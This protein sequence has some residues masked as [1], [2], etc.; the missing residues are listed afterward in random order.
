MTPRDSGGTGVR[1]GEATHWRRP[2]DEQPSLNRYLQ[3]LRERSRLIAITIA[4]TFAVAVLYLLVAD[5]QYQAE[6]DLLV[7]P[8]A[9]DQA[10]TGLPLLIQ[11]NDPTR[12]VETAARLTTTRDV[13][14]RAAV[15]VPGDQ[16]EDELLGMVE[17]APVAQSN[18]VAITATADSPELA[19]QVANA[20]AVSLVRDRTQ[21]L[22]RALDQVIA[23]LRQ[24]L[25]SQSA[26][27]EEGIQLRTQLSQLETLRAGPDPSIR[28]ETRATPPDGPSA[29][30]P[31]LTLAA[32]LV[33]GLVLGIG[34]A[35]ALHSV[36]PRLRR[37]EQLRELYQL[38][39][40][41]RI[42]KETRARTATLGRRIL[43]IGPRRKRRKALGPGQLSPATLEAYRTLRTMLAATHPTTRGAGR[44]VLITGP[45]PS[46]GKTTTAI[47]LS[48]SLALGGHRV[49]LI[50][51]D[52][53]RPTV[54]EALGV[55]PAIGI[56]KVLLGTE[57]LEDALVPADPFG[58]KLRLLL[59]DH[60]D[61][62][63]PEVLSL[64]TAGALLDEAGA[65]ADYV[66][67]DSPPLTEVIDALPLAREVDDVVVVVR[68]GGSN[69]T[70]LAR[71]GDLLAQNGIEPSGFVVVGVGRSEKETYYLSAQRERMSAYARGFEDVEEEP[72]PRTGSV[73]S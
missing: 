44:S 18:I 70:Q 7:T 12:D 2:R 41:A 14:R 61:E 23:N 52:F 66:V 34:G 63:L 20:F 71:L 73:R 6:A 68:L 5:K 56:G 38:P 15:L 1:Q 37:E 65:L 24:R 46:E 35:F 59:V 47:N 54:G 60:A 36:D 45:S 51:A 3:I 33:A 48:A 26:N 9:S 21:Q 17:A 67:I 40:L 30:K 19:A 29:P 53:R 64:P 43:L 25:E 50:E 72:D 13:A 49:I 22:H 39:I 11:S 31:F 69:L 4:A 57:K 58:D 10:P 62:W 27:T 28:L 42:P 8:V 55:R 16:D 32:G